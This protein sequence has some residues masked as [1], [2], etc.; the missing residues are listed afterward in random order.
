[1]MTIDQFQIS[2]LIRAANALG[3][4]F[5]RLPPFDISPA[6]LRAAAEHQ[7]GLHDWGEADFWPGFVQA[8]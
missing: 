5:A 6:G 8:S 2:P 3:S 7:T 4:P 1:M